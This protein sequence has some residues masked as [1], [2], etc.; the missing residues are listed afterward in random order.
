M[1]FGSTAKVLANSKIKYYRISEHG[2]V[3][4][5]ALCRL[6]QTSKTRS[7]LGPQKLSFRF[8]HKAVSCFELCTSPYRG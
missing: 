4:Q 3:K 8:Q 5:I 1:R 7:C 6:A 2:M